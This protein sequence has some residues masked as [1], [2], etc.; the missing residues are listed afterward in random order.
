MILKYV[1]SCSAMTD[2]EKTKFKESLDNYLIKIKEKQ[3]EINPLLNP[4][5]ASSPV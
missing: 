4:F 5:D 3:G 2:W 1:E